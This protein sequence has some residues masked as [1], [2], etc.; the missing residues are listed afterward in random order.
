M[1][2]Y[3]GKGEYSVSQLEQIIEQQNEELYQ[4]KTL[5]IKYLDR[6]K[7]EYKEY[8]K[9]NKIFHGVEQVKYKIRYNAMR[10]F[11]LDCELV[12]FIDIESMEYEVNSELNQSF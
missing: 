11:C 10:L 2:H 8:Q 5:H 7:Q 12:S 9:A 3:K 6:L 4:L 1:I